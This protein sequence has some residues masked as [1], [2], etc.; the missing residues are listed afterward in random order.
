L[1]GECTTKEKNTLVK[2]SA[3][4]Y[5]ISSKYVLQYEIVIIKIFLLKKISPTWKNIANEN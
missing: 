4:Q 2:H 3:P 1:K 5:F